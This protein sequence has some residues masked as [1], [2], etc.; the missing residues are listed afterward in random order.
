MVWTSK[1]IKRTLQYLTAGVLLNLAVAWTLAIVTTP[2]EHSLAGIYKGFGTYQQSVRR[3][4]TFGAQVFQLHRVGT[5]AYPDYSESS[6]GLGAVP[7][8]ANVGQESETRLI[9][10]Y[11]WPFI[12]LKWNGYYA[13]NNGEVTTIRGGLKLPLYQVYRRPYGSN[14]IPRALPVIP[15]WR[16]FLLNSAVY[17]GLCVVVCGL[18][19]HLSYRRR[20]RLGLCRRCGYPIGSS[21]KCTECGTAIRPELNK[22]SSP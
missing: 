1:Y 17:A 6:P 14:D 4:Q 10:G 16:G 3:W 9:V 21:E 8:W 7:K 20:S 2:F 13:K 18:F 22:Q 5:D 15:I 11:G 19:S 12:A